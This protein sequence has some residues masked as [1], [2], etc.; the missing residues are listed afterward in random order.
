M[1]EPHKLAQLLNVPILVAAGIVL[2]RLARL[3]WPGRRWLPVAALAF[4]AACPV[5]LRVA[6]M[7]QPEPLDV[8]LSVLALYLAAR[9]LAEQRFSWP[10]AAL[11]GLVLGA[12]ELVRQFSV[13]TFAVV[14]AAFLLAVVSSRELRR[15]AAAALGVTVA[16]TALVSSPWWIYRSIEYGNPVFD[17]PHP[18]TPLFERRPAS[19]YI[20]TGWPEVLTHSY[21]PRFANRVWPQLYSDTWGDWYGVFAWPAKSQ[22]APSTAARTW[23]GFQQVLGFVPTVLAI[24]GWLALLALSLVRRDPVRLLP[25]LLP[26]AGLA[27]FFYFTISYP[28]RDG[29][30]IKPLYLLTTAPAWALCFAWAVDRVASR[31]PGRVLVVALACAGLLAL[32]FLPYRGA[33]G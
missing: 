16:V 3:L 23:L 18:S 13:W 5:V 33:L 7:F 32:P 10:S 4:F 11:L 9:I 12:G 31:R 20:G 1:G 21:R 24:G 8:L 27:G 19:F 2:L 15:P 29:D 6:S 22:A 17:R 28:T 26:L 25:A 14:V 30:V